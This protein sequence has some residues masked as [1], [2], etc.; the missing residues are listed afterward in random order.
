ML[1]HG[2][3]GDTFCM[4]IVGSLARVLPCY[5]N[6]SVRE[7]DRD[8]FEPASQIS[9]KPSSKTRPALLNTPL[10]RRNM[11]G[12]S[13]CSAVLAI[14]TG[15]F[16]GSIF[17]DQNTVWDKASVGNEVFLAENR[18]KLS[19]LVYGAS[20]SPEMFG[21]SLAWQ[22]T[23]SDQYARQQEQMME[24]LDTVINDFKIRDI[25]LGVQWKNAV[26]ADNPHNVN[27]DFYHPVI[28]K[29][30]KEGVNITLNPGAIKTF[31]YPEM[32]VP[33]NLLQQIPLP[34]EGAVVI[35]QDPLAQRA[36]EYMGKLYSEI[37][38]L[39]PGD[40]Q[41]SFVAIQPE[42]EGFNAFGNKKWVMSDGYY[43]QV[44]QLAHTYFPEASIL[45][46]SAGAKDL[47]KIRTLYND[48]LKDVPKLYGRLIAGI[49]YY[50]LKPDSVHLPF[51]KPALEPVT[52]SKLKSPFSMDEFTLHSYE[53][54]GSG[55]LTEITES[56][57]EKWGKEH[58]PQESS[59]GFKFK[60]LRMAPFTDKI[61]R[62]W[63]IEEFA[64][65]YVIGDGRSNP[66]G[67]GTKDNREVIDLVRR[68]NNGELKAPKEPLI[69]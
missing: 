5:Y 26:D 34:A 21:L 30:V 57:A 10:T 41:K 44:I 6:A 25:R 31:R 23:E 62:I 28:D 65:R 38:R 56:Q 69:F 42:N 39:W 40:A 16:E 51:V 35:P 20:F 59:Q 46:N 14:G 45:L 22:E 18:E 17:V 27:L 68:V 37:Q 19:H 52:I 24:C 4:K 13:I 48:V 54:A 63:G 67:W 60:T 49:D 9:D 64:R 58:L 11:L 61:E 1:L 36:I 53:V 32:H 29:C 66:K 12:A 8:I 47:S 33:E 50:Y 15:T 3:H 55:I 2:Q 43:R 7:Q